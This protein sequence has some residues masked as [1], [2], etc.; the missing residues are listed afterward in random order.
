MRATPP[1]AVP[2]GPPPFDTLFQL[3][4]GKWVCQAVSVVAR[5]KIA[6]LLASGPK[7]AAELAAA[8]KTHPG[9]LYRILRAVAA[10][11]VL[12]EGDDGRFSLPPVGEYLR[13]D[14]P[15]SL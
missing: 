9:H 2:P 13:S 12:A 14:V 1:E 11:G 5:F 8:T 4:A 7:T 3:I 6:D 10:V 15:G